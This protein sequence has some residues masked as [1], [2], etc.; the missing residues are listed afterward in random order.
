MQINVI[1]R[2]QQIEL[3]EQVFV[4]FFIVVYNGENASVLSYAFFIF[5]ICLML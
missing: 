3:Q 2:T 1:E 4:L 5:L